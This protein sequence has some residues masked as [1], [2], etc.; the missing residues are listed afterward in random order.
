MHS[1]KALERR[2]RARKENSSG[3]REQR[4]NRNSLEWHLIIA[5]FANEN[6]KYRK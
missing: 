2:E 6:D 4:L 3:A 1:D 5:I